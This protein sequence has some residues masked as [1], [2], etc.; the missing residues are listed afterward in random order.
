M[1][2]RQERII[3]LTKSYKI[4]VYLKTLWCFWVVKLGVAIYSEKVLRKKITEKQ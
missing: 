3:Y 1:A 2:W 4:A